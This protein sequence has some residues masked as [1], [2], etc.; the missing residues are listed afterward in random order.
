MSFS[1]WF[2]ISAICAFVVPVAAMAK[3]PPTD[4]VS[5]EFT[6]PGQGEVLTDSEIEIRLIINGDNSNELD[7]FHWNFGLVGSGVINM[8]NKTT[9]DTN[10]ND[11]DFFAEDA[12]NG[13]YEVCGYAA[14]IDHSHL[15]ETICVQFKLAKIGAQLFL[16]QDG[17]TITNF[18][19]ATIDYSKYGADA[20]LIRYQLDEGTVLSTSEFSGSLNMPNIGNGSHLLR[21]WAEDQDG[22]ILGNIQERSFLVKSPL[23][24]NRAQKMRESAKA[25]LAQGV[26]DSSQHRRTIKLLK[27][28]RQ[29]GEVNPS[30]LL[31]SSKNLKKAKHLLRKA[32]DGNVLAS[33]KFLKLT[34]GM[35]SSGG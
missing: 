26:V 9:P 10:G 28:M 21:F 22:N 4:G 25:A 3:A 6:Q 1:N 8:L 5:I 33:E 12:P 27:K 32:L 29:G 19:N 24:K 2:F 17:D 15:S 7:H 35:I 16:P 11:S 23:S 34:K 31:L 13:D 14:R 20:V 30:N 18:D